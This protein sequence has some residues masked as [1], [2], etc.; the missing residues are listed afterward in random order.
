MFYSGLVNLKRV[1]AELPALNSDSSV[2]AVSKII[3]MSILEAVLRALPKDGKEEIVRRLAA[4]MNDPE[5]LEYLVDELGPEIEDVICNAFEAALEEI[6]DS[7][8]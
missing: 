2:K 4:N 6:Q 7:Q 8:S 1:V 5:T 3:H